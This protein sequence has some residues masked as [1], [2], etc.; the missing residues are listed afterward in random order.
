MRFQTIGR[1]KGEI[2]LPVKGVRLRI[3]ILWVKIEQKGCYNFNI[4]HN[5]RE[6]VSDINGWVVREFLQGWFFYVT[7][8]ERVV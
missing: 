7:R 4:V 1:V 8:G 5:R 3:N 6:D 2:Y